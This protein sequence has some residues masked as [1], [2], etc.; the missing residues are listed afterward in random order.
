M[1]TVSVTG[2]EHLG[3]GLQERAQLDGGHMA[4]LTCHRVRVLIDKLEARVLLDKGLRL[5]RLKVA[6][7][8]S[9]VVLALFSSFR[10]GR[11]P[12]AAREG[13]APTAR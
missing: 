11:K 8:V 3:A 4:N 12:L 13:A 5:Y 2:A 10:K 9:H 7:L 6:F 1:A